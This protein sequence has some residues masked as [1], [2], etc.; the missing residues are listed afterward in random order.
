MA[1]KVVQLDLAT[2]ELVVTPLMTEASE[3]D[4]TPTADGIPRADGAGKIAAGWIPDS[5]RTVNVEEPDGVPA[6]TAIS[7]LVFDAG[8]VA[9][10]GGGKARITGGGGDTITLQGRPIAA[11]A[12]ALGQTLIWSGSAW[13]PGDVISGSSDWMTNAQLVGLID[14]VNRTFDLPAPAVPSTLS[15]FVEAGGALTAVPFAQ[16]RYQNVAL[17]VTPAANGYNGGGFYGSSPSSCLVDGVTSGAFWSSG[18]T[19]PVLRWVFAEAVAI[20]RTSGWGE[21]NWGFGGFA[22]YTLE[23]SL[24]AGATWI[25]V[26]TDLPANTQNVIAPT[27]AAATHW[28]VTGLTKQGYYEWLI[29]EV[30][31]EVALTVVTQ[32]V[33]DTAPVVGTTPQASFRI[34][35]TGDPGTGSTATVPE[36]VSAATY[37]YL[38]SHY[39]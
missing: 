31:L 26:V 22:T 18:Y 29:Y 24:D 36:G 21:A 7:T 19:P 28:R 9:F 2:G 14:G 16:V 17:G 34:A 32:V 27:P 35:R 5:V 25:T 37:L 38:A 1:R 30:I 8:T 12:P 11:N 13:V 15:V 6:L 39:I 10:L 23:Q 33:L 4:A 20:T 3:V